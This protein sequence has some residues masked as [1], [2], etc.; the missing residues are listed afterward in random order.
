MAPKPIQIVDENDRPLKSGTM[1]DA[2]RDGLWHRI[3]RVVIEDE[4]GRFLLQ[5]RSAAMST[6]PGCWDTSAAGHV[7]FGET[8]SVAA[9]REA[10]EE[11]GLADLSLKEIESYRSESVQGEKILNRFNKTYQSRIGSKRQFTPDPE[12]VEELRWFS[13]QEVADLINDHPDEVTDG[14][15]HAFP[16]LA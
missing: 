9:R 11:T 10:L 8:Y 15:K 7:D 6:F 12:E 13:K 3:A 5:K 4:N 14:L 2:Q 1:E 16:H